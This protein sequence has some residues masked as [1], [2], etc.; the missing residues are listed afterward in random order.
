MSEMR[1]KGKRMTMQRMLDKLSPFTSWVPTASEYDGFAGCPTH[2]VS[3][4]VA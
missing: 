4:E 2:T 1:K 3:V